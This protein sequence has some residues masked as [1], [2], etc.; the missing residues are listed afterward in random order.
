[1]QR[2]RLQP[3]LLGR[4][5]RAGLDRTD[6]QQNACRSAENYL[7]YRAFLRSGPID[8]LLYEGFTSEQAQYGVSQ[9][10]L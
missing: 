1:M 5:P 2:T 4:R 6:S 8:Q 7:Y 10:G 3:R 9:N